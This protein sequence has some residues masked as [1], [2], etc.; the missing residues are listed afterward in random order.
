MHT[1]AHIRVP[2]TLDADRANRLADAV[3]VCDAAVIVL[4]GH[5]DT[6]C[7]GMDFTAL[8]AASDDRAISYGVASFARCVRAIRAAEMPVI[9]VVDGAT[10]GGG[11]GIAAASDCVIATHRATFGLPEA[12]FG[13]VPGV[14]LPVLRD[15]MT[16]QHARSLALAP[17]ARGVAEAQRIG[18]VD[19][20]VAAPELDAAVRRTVRELSR[21][22]RGA[23]KSLR[24]LGAETAGLNV[25]AAITRGADLTCALLRSPPVIDALRAFALGEEA[26]WLNE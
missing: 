2:E 6:F 17:H 19:L 13:L 16:A 26:P 18:L 9:A 8:I 21:A 10:L 1:V 12:L 24:R 4:E 5:A 3:E 25:D 7:R 14:V 23:V 20:A 15:R 11:V 22:K